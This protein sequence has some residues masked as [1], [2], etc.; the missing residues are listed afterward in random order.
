M[1]TGWGQCLRQRRYGSGGAVSNR[2]SVEPLGPFRRDS[3][4]GFF[5]ARAAGRP[6]LNGERAGNST[7][8]RQGSI[9]TAW[10]FLAATVLLFSAPC[11]FVHLR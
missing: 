4:P 10:F 8:K 11:G 2:G 1:V 9:P 5:C 7:G 6:W 3:A